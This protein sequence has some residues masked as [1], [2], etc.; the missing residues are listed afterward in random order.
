MKR[1]LEW[2]LIAMAVLVIFEGKAFGAVNT[3][4][5][6]SESPFVSVAKSTFYGSLFGTAI[7]CAIM[8]IADGDDDD[9]FKVSFVSGTALGLGYGIY[10]VATRPSD[11]T[12]LFRLDGG[13]PSVGFPAFKIRPTKDGVKADVSLFAMRF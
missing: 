4:R 10:H 13:G 5:E 9:I 12:A 1:K 11:T 3:V 8:L 7:G 6:D 2:M